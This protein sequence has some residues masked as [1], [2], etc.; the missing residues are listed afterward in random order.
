MTYKICDKDRCCFDTTNIKVKN[1]Q[2]PCVSCN[3]IS[4]SEY[5]HKYCYNCCKIDSTEYKYH[6]SKCRDLEIPPPPK[7]RR[8][9]SL[10]YLYPSDI[11]VID[12]PLRTR[13]KYDKVMDE[14]LDF[15][16]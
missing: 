14:I 6:H 8:E 11:E 2:E 1:V 16:K 12:V 7:L 15:V 10:T 13:L 3:C 5:T 9:M 4:I